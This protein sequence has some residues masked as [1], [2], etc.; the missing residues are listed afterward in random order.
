MSVVA[1][2]PPAEAV[3]H[4]GVGRMFAKKQYAQRTPEWYEVRRGLITASDAASALGVPPFKS[5][6][7]D[8]RAETLRKKLDNAPFS[9][10]FVAHGQR[11][12]AEACAL[13]AEAL[14][15]EVF[16]FGLVVHDA[17]PWLGASPDGVTRSGKLVEIKCP[18]KRAIVPGEVPHHYAA[19][20]Q[21][22]L[23]VCDLD[24]CIFCQYKPA[25]LNG[26]GTGHVLDIV[27]V[28]RDRRWFEAAR[29][30]LHRFWEDYTARLPTHV[31]PPLPPAPVCLVDDEMYAC[32]A[33]G[34]CDAC[35]A[36]RRPM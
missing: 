8:I 35:G 19:Q 30:E 4:P 33:C 5:Y 20:V 23:E 34:A 22:Q 6:R 27:V 10:M 16:E 11:Y 2:E 13:M 7:G 29:P 12:E 18:M 14:G 1:F 24:S 9:N 26:Y 25:G 31:P 36:V 28:E 15:E 17:L 32:G 3:C 21:V